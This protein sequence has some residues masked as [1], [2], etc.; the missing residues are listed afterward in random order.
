[1]PPNWAN[2]TMWTGDARPGLARRGRR[3][4]E[5]SVAARNFSPSK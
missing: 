1:M 2:R 5:F 3:Q 4:P